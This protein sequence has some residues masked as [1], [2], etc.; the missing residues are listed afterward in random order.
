MTF[1]MSQ[2][3]WGELLTERPGVL[4]NILQDTGHFTHNEELSGP[5]VN[6]AGDRAL[7]GDCQ[8]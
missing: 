6:S 8:H 5:N 7:R 4:L 2:L 3:G 1:W